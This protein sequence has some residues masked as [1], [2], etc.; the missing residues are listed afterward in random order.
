MSKTTGQNDKNASNN[1]AHFYPTL[2][3]TTLS[4]VR[5]KLNKISAQSP[6][7]K[8]MLCTIKVMKIVEYAI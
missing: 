2:P 6:E 4:T 3:T 8:S 7:M 5:E 1:K